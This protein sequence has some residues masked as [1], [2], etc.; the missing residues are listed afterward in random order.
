MR[1]DQ[2][3]DISDI[4]RRKAEGC[5][6]IAARSFEE[7]LR[8]LEVMRDRVAPLREAR[9]MRQDQQRTRQFA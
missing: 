3:P 7:K 5:V 1:L 6:E 8:M 4:L 9:E 2:H